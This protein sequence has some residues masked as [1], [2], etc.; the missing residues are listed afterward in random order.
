M[1]ACEISAIQSKNC[2]L[3][4]PFGLEFDISGLAK[5]AMNVTVSAGSSNYQYFLSPCAPVGLNA[6]CSRLTEPLPI[7]VTQIDLAS[8]VCRSLGKG[9]GT[10]RYADNTLSLTYFSGDACRNGIS[11]TSII[12]FTCPES[13][14]NSCHSGNCVSFVTENE[15]IYEFEWV[16]PLACGRA[17]SKF[18]CEFKLGGLSYDLGRLTEGTNPT[19]AAVSYE[20]DTE[21]YLINP[22]G[23]LKGTGENFTPAKLC[24]LRLVP[25]PCWNSSICQIRRNSQLAIGYGTFKGFDKTSL[26]AFDKNVFSVTT[27]SSSNG[28]RA[29]VRYICETGR[30]QSFPV[31][32]S[33]I[34]TNVSEF[35]WATYAACPQVSQVGS[36]CMVQEKST[37]FSFNL[38][39]LSGRSYVFNNTKYSYKFRVCGSLP[40]SECGAGAAMCQSQL[41]GSN[42]A[43]CG[44]LNSTLMYADSSL[45]LVYSGGQSCKGGAL[46][47]TTITFLCNPNTHQPVVENVTEIRHCE[48]LV[49][50][51]TKLA[52]PPAY[53]ATECVLFTPSGTVY[54]LRELSRLTG[55][56]QAEGS[57][58]SVYVINVCRPLNLQGIG[59]CNPL[60]SA[61]RITSN[62]ASPNVDIGYASS[63]SL[64]VSSTGD[65]L[66]L[67]Y[68]YSTPSSD[69]QTSHCSKI[70]TN[71]K[72]TCNANAPAEVSTTM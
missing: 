70:F 16:T 35:H 6:Q 28:R 14:D 36:N 34:V 31:F 65:Y 48:Y 59:G 63:A 49:E 66:Y 68:N 2:K 13:V 24:N 55:N 58:G 42:S 15:C 52:C 18:S 41:S 25:Q 61:C 46:R 22:C 4:T 45:K 44:R 19:Y 12:T 60:S 72:L 43:S 27:K 21:C 38:T 20:N 57:D 26:Q 54:D 47:T 23:E 32:I 69:S 39:S 33:Q 5:R 67:R 10:L 51:R 17:R 62:P 11:R 53:R 7:R 64:T 40:A 71:I 30:L 29:L 50:M 9:N 1:Y 8:S 37:G 3:T 56:W